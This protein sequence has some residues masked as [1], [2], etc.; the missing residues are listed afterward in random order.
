MIDLGYYGVKETPS[1]LAL[2]LRISP[3]D[4]KII[5]Y[6]LSNWIFEHFICFKDIYYSVL[7]FQ[8]M[9]IMFIIIY[10]WG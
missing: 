1:F 8:R 2:T 6:L 3:D 10:S 9:F 7:R 5:I 4:L